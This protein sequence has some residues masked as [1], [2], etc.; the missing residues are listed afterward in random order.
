ML[1]ML[2]LDLNLNEIP[3]AFCIRPVTKGPS[4]K[5]SQDQGENPRGISHPGCDSD[6]NSAAAYAP[7]EDLRQ[8]RP[9][10]GLGLSKGVE[11][12]DKCS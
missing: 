4:P 5:D 7:L 12:G 6:V 2:L 3:R 10:S 9:A 11:T 8:V 1:R